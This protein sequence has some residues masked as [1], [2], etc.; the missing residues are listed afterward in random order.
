MTIGHICSYIGFVQFLILSFDFLDFKRIDVAPY[1]RYI[2]WDSV[3]M[4]AICME[5]M[6]LIEIHKI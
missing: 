2:G 4:E 5:S 3:N 1:R 6:M